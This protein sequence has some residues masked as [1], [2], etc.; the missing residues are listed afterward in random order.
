MLQ[1]VKNML[2]CAV[3][4]TVK[5]YASTIRSYLFI[6]TPISRFHLFPVEPTQKDVRE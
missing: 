4:K 3:N 6:V 1:H 5:S 2:S